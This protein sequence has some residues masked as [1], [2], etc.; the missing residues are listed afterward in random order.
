MLHRLHGAR[1]RGFP[2]LSLRVSFVFPLTFWEFDCVGLR[3]EVPAESGL[4]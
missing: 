3:D 1:P 2:L 4:A